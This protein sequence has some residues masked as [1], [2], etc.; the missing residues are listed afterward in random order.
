MNSIFAL[1]ISVKDLS[2]G[3]LEVIEILGND[4]FKV[5]KQPVLRL[6]SFAKPPNS[7]EDS[8][9]SESSQINKMP[10]VTSTP[11]SSTSRVSPSSGIV[12]LTSDIENNSTL[13]T[14]LTRKVIDPSTVAALKSKFKTVVVPKNFKGKQIISVKNITN[15]YNV[16][17]TPGNPGINSE[18]VITSVSQKPPDNSRT[19]I[20]IPSQNPLHLSS[21][22][23]VQMRINKLP[24]KGQRQIISIQ[25][26]KV[27]EKTTTKSLTILPNG[28][29]TVFLQGASMPYSNIFAN[30]KGQVVRVKT[31]VPNP[32]SKIMKVLN[33]NDAQKV[34]ITPLHK[35]V[36]I[37]KIISSHTRETPNLK[38]NQLNLKGNQQ[39]SNQQIPRNILPSPKKNQST[40]NNSNTTQSLSKT[41]SQR[42]AS[43]I[44][45]IIKPGEQNDQNILSGQPINE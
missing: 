16:V 14:H 19:I 22:K 32:E 45:R 15:N 9:Q 6:R 39:R 26:G 13:K 23:A 25:R 38:S 36:I 35:H 44:V 5:N 18:Q 28:N 20:R 43:N 31:I 21:R 41:N 30:Q 34:S 4:P 10:K 12:D 17:N 42:I 7:W 2:P 27:N 40:T 24:D 1:L 3:D 29:G 33:L 37:N 11:K 8:L